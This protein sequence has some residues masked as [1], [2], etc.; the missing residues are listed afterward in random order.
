MDIGAPE[1]I[2]VLIIVILLFG[3]KKVPELARSLGQAQREFKKGT[4]E[5]F[6]S[7]DG[8]GDA[9]TAEAAKPEPAK[10]ETSATEAKPD[11]KPDTQ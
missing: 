2:I 7:T 9:A 6:T 3:A 8:E 10:I 4:K 5:G 1:I 11:P